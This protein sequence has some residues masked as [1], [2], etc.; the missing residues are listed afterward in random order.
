MEE[1]KLVGEGGG[2]AEGVSLDSRRMR[3]SSRQGRLSAI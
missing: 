2:S 3:E 1:G